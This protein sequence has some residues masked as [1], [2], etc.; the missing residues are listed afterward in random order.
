MRGVFLDTQTMAPD[1]LDFSALTATLG[2]WQLHDA[3]APAQ[4]AERLAGAEVVVS[5]KV[6]LDRDALAQAA[7]LKLVCVSATGTNN[8]DTEAARQLGIPVCNVSGYAGPSVAQHTLALMLGL[9]TRWHD[10]QQDVQRGDWSRSPMFCLMHRPVVELAGKHL[11]IVGSG[12]LGQAVAS[13]A[14]AFSMRV[15]FAASLAPGATM[16][17]SRRPL[18]QLL[19]EADWVSLHCPLTDQTAKLVDARFLGLMPSHSF[20]IN[21]A[22]GGLVDEA[23]LAAALRERRIAGAALDVLSQEPPPADH[24]LLAA[25]IPNLLLTPHNAWISRE[26]RQRL[27]DGVTANIRAWQ[28]GRLSNCVNGLEVA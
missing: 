23:A 7:E 25:D 13:L 19:P 22:R 15:S 14:Q 9:A 3:T 18:Q 12:A 5:N 26:C 8:V 11:V 4:L 2:E 21:T 27:L 28:G 17:S 10:Y 24:P 16:D 1:D 20:L 6:V